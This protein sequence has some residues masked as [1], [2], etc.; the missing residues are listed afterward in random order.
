MR[1]SLPWLLC[2]LATLSCRSPNPPVPDPPDRVV[3]QRAWRAAARE[4]RVAYS[5]E[6]GWRDLAAGG[7]NIT[8][9][10]ANRELVVRAARAN[11]RLD[12]WIL[13]MRD[14]L[15]K[16][17]IT[18][19]AEERDLTV[20]RSAELRDPMP[21]GPPGDPERGRTLFE[22]KRVGCLRCHRH[23]DR[24]Q[25]IGP[26]LDG[27]GRGDERW[28]REDILDPFEAVHPGH[29]RVQLTF[30]NGTST[31]GV[32][33]PAATHWLVGDEAGVLR[34]IDPRTIGVWRPMPGS[35]MPLDYDVDLGP[36]EIE[37][38]VAFLCAEP[39]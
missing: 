16:G 6:I 23:G 33:R 22:S 5:G 25:R 35:I 1:R 37:D 7:T 12:G 17:R 29:L 34:R 30:A 36:G 14:P 8:V 13:R 39:R 38:I 20:D 2:G 11:F 4:I 28:V 26:D 32:A 19:R 21:A 24:G 9:R 18:V 27:F 15:P 3:P 31:I 10:A